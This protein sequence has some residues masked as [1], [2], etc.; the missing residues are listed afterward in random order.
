MPA[1]MPG[2]HVR[3]VKHTLF[4]HLGIFPGN[5]G[6]YKCGQATH[7]SGTTTLTPD[8]FIMGAARRVAGAIGRTPL[9][10]RPADTVKSESIWLG[11]DLTGLQD[12][13][14]RTGARS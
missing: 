3:A 13:I 10:S 6:N 9:A 2:L 11:R 14:Q 4:P 5:V 1:L 7:L 12:G 8:V